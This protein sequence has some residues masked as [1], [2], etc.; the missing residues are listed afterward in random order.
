L[1]AL[2]R[3]SLIAP[4]LA[5][6]VAQGAALFLYDCL[7]A[8]HVTSIGLPARWAG[9]ALAPGILLEIAV[10]AL[11]PFLL[12]RFTPAGLLLAGLVTATIRWVLTALVD[13]PWPLVSIQALHGISFGAYW[14][15]GVELL[16]SR[17]PASIRAS[18]QALFYSCF[19]IGALGSAGLVAALLDQIQTTGLYAVGAGLT[20]V[21]TAVLLVSLLRVG[22]VVPQP[23]LRPEQQPPAG[24]TRNTP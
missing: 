3:Q 9:I 1:R 5:V 20:G 24:V 15:G 17:A 14:I 22:P 10:M 21:A 4:V 19:W 16:R 11:A 6:T 8:V 23:L 2:S 7:F 13:D 12:R 18:A